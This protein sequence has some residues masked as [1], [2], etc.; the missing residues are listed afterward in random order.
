MFVWKTFFPSPRSSVCLPYIK[1]AIFVLFLSRNANETL[2][3]V[4]LWFPRD[5]FCCFLLLNVFVFV[6]KDIV[7]PR[8]TGWSQLKPLV[9]HSDFQGW[10]DVY[11]ISK[12]WVSAVSVGGYLGFLKSGLRRAVSMLFKSLPCPWTMSP[13]AKVIAINSKSLCVIQFLTTSSDF[14]I[15]LKSYYNFLGHSPENIR[16]M[17][18]AMIGP[19]EL[20]AIF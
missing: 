1:T 9:M 3:L 2:V 5:V 6:C 16:T 13:L 7:I 18:P 8:M 14:W 10:Q 15:Y 12:W 19:L 11:H 17:C 20:C 4:G